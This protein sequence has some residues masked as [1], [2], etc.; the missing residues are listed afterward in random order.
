MK[1]GFLQK[2]GHE[3]SAWHAYVNLCKLVNVNVVLALLHTAVIAKF[4]LKSIL[5]TFQKQ[6]TVAVFSKN[7][8]CFS[9]NYLCKVHTKVD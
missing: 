8:D 1:S 5:T 9:I 2:C 4:L 3:W 6:K 7:E